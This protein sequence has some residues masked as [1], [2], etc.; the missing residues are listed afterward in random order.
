[1]S[2]RL[3]RA[4]CAAIVVAAGLVGIPACKKTKPTQSDNPNPAPV[5]AGSSLNPPPGLGPAA[6]GG[7]PNAPRTPIFGAGDIRI[8]AMRPVAQDDLKQIG[9][10]LHNYHDRM[11][12]LPTAIP[13]KTGKPGLSWRVALLPELGHQN[14]HQQCKLDEPW[15]SPHN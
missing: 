1:M 5:P 14:L 8:A 7:D 11:N 4:A 9:L 13:D 6:S 3:T 12:G 10:A 15:D 2:P